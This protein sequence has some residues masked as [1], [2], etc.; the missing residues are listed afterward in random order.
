LLPFKHDFFLSVPHLHQTAVSRIKVAITFPDNCAS[1]Y[2]TAKN[3]LLQNLAPHQGKK[4]H[5]G[6]EN[7]SPHCKSKGKSLRRK[8]SVH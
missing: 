5:A 1:N 8:N 2:N 3:L 4:N 6:S 7:H